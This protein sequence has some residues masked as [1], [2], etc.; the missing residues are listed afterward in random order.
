MVNRHASW[1]A[2]PS[3][4]L[5]T[6]VYIHIHTHT[7]NN[8]PLSDLVDNALSNFYYKKI[9]EILQINATTFRYF[10]VIIVI[11]RRLAVWIF[12]VCPC[13]IDNLSVLELYVPDPVE[14]GLIYL[15]MF[16]VNSN[17]IQM[18][19]KKLHISWL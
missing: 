17:K 1:Y 6:T 11:T 5:F 12:Q 3:R 2:Y 18:V 14:R 19:T 7:H 13:C 9:L 10:I 16:H 8:P 15:K 4:H